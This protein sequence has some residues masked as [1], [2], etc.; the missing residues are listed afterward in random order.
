MLHTV[1]IPST[2]DKQTKSAL[3]NKSYTGQEMKQ[4]LSLQPQSPHNDQ[5][6]YDA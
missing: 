3:A 6:S 2:K 4:A 1:Y 5:K